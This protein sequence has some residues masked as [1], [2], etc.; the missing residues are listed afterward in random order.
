MSGGILQQ[1]GP[2]TL[3]LGGSNTY[4]STTGGLGTIIFGG[5]ISVSSDANL[6]GSLD[7]VFINNGALYS[8][9]G[10]TTARPIF[11]GAMEPTTVTNGT[12]SVAAGQTTT[13][14]GSVTNAGSLGNLVIAGGGTVVLTGTNNQITTGVYVE[15]ASTLLAGNGSH[16]SATGSNPAPRSSSGR[17]LIPPARPR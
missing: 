11:T 9:T 1:F 2:G 14:T 12:L 4:G 15:S 5:T 16:G 6:G 10:F 3:V 7:G 13:F 17:A 8:S